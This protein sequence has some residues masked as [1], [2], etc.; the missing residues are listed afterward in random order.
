MKQKDL[1]NQ[2]GLLHR[3]LDGGDRGPAT[4]RNMDRFME[5]EKNL[6]ILENHEEKVTDGFASRVMAA[7]PDK[8]CRP[9][10]GRFWT[11]WPERRFWAIPGLAG[12]LAM[13]LI[14]S[15]ITLLPPRRSS[16]RIPVV[17]DFYAPKARE[18][19]LVGTFSNW[20]PGIFPLKGPDAVGYWV[21]VVNLPPGRYEYAF[22]INGS[23]LVP[24]DD[25]EAVR[26]DSFGG[27]NSV[28]L[29]KGDLRRGV[30]SETALSFDQSHS[31]PSLSEQNRTKWRPVID[32]GMSGGLSLD[33]LE[34]LAAAMAAAGFDPDQARA[35]LW[36]LLQNG[37]IDTPVDH[38]FLE[39]HEGILKQALPDNLR[40]IL[41][42]R[43]SAFEEA[44]TLLD[45]SGHDSSAQT[46]TALLSATAF[47]LETGQQPSYLRGI[48]DAGKGRLSDQL[49]AVI[50][51]GEI[52]QHAGLE[53]EPLQRIMKDCLLKNLQA[54]QIERV[55]KRL[56]QR[57]QQGADPKTIDRDLWTKAHQPQ[58]KHLSHSG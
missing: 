50:E 55:M 33:Q 22:L 58:T 35:A 11:F 38:L 21:I 47:A 31:P 25:G 48:L 15:A 30:S 3:L 8:P 41:A 51:A 32:M 44:K 17:L 52:L 29:L 13:F 40:T 45:K 2:D 7:L 12:A 42:K 23:K 39:I 53:P 49:T 9:W 19:Q 14:I 27:E 24:D 4:T 34:T 43:E 6:K 20:T 26:P 5:Y 37:T 36:P 57:I 54:V 56:K 16:I 28:L 10:F 1:E 18:V 46:N